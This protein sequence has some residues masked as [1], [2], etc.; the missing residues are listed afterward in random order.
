MNIHKKLLNMGFKVCGPHRVT[1]DWREP[2]RMVPDDKIIENKLL[3]GKWTRVE[4][5]KIHPK[6]QNF[7]KLIFDENLT[8][9]IKT[10][11]NL[12]I[13]IWIEGKSVEDGVKNIYT[14]SNNNP[15]NNKV[16]IFSKLPIKVQRDFILNDI[17]K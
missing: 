2:Y 3:N 15:I 5:K 4:I 10:N 16:D 6:W 17:F 1:T 11:Q 8:I 14:H 13:D 7:F 9:W 12:I